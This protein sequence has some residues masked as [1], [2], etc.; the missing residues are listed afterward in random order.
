M[1]GV[2]MSRCPSR[3]RRRAHRRHRRR[4]PRQLQ[5]DV[6]GRR[7]DRR[8]HGADDRGLDGETLADPAGRATVAEQGVPGYECGFW[9][10]L[11]GPKGMDATL[12][13]KIQKDVA[14][15]L[16]DPAVV[17]YLAKVGSIAIGSTPEQFDALIRADSEKWGPVIKAANIKV[18]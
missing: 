10:G 8:R 18:Q 5:S 16:K 9:A 3:W 4:Y 7:A 1:A 14:A 6:G 11:L 2:K 13:A 12:V 15:A 17:A